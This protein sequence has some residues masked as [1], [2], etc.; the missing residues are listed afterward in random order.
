[1]PAGPLGPPAAVTSVAGA[2]AQMA[3]IDAAT[4]PGDGLACFNRMY[5]G[6]TREVDSE[7][8][9]GFF[10]DPAFMTALDVAFANLY[11]TAAGAAGDPA[12]VPLAWRPLIEQRAAAGIEPIQFALAGMNAHINHDLPLA[13][14]STCTELAT[15]PAAGAHLADYQKVDQLLDAAEQSVRQSFESAPELAVDHHLQAVSNLVASWTI[16]SARDLAWNNSLLLWELRDIP[17]AR[18]LFLDSL[19]ATAATASRLL[20]VAV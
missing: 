11:F 1:M 7:L 19:A 16:N 5:L 13:V 8:G 10:A 15:A 17:L 6:V 14:V 12:A 3:A 20:L 18:Q 9:Q 2:I 4:A